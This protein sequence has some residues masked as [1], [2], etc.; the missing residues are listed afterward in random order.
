MTF[1]ADLRCLTIEIAFVRCRGSVNSA[2][3]LECVSSSRLSHEKFDFQR[4]C[5]KAF[6]FMIVVAEKLMI[7]KINARDVRRFRFLGSD[8]ASYSRA[9]SVG[10]DKMFYV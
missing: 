4:D 3:V 9:F 6:A 10:T 8:S 5:T 1:S 2:Y 7:S